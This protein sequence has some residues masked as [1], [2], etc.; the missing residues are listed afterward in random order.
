M[1]KILYF[2]IGLNILL[3]ALLVKPYWNDFLVDANIPPYLK[4][5]IYVMKTSNYKV[6]KTTKAYIVM[7]GDS[8]T[9]GVDWHELLGR[10]DIINRG[11]AGD[12]SEGMLNRLHY[13]YSLHPKYVFIMGGIN[14]I[15]HHVLTPNEIA[16]NYDK[17]ISALKNRNIKPVITS[18]LYVAPTEKKHKK[19]NGNVDQLNA[20][21][22]EIANEKGIPF[23]DLNSKLAKGNSLNPKYTVDGIHLLGNA[24]RIWGNE[25]EKVLKKMEAE[26]DI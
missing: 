19:I 13:I 25:I 10:N 18:T 9:Q 12:Y 22:K 3:L 17:M 11:I 14:D 15:R 23:I 24:Y 8:I 6:Y 16:K 1:K 26:S 20:L 4:N 21:L 5:K 2:S 7:L